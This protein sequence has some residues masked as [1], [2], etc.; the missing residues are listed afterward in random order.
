VTS[1]W[2]F[3]NP[4]TSDFEASVWEQAVFYCYW[5]VSKLRGKETGREGKIAEETALRVRG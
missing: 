5:V 1:F 3:H 2:I 4:P